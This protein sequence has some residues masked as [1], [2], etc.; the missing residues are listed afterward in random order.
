VTL[1]ENGAME[2]RTLQ[3]KIDEM[4]GS[5]QR[6]TSAAFYTPADIEMSALELFYD[7]P[8]IDVLRPIAKQLTR[9]AV[10][11]HRAAQR[12]WP[13]VTDCDL[14]DRAFGELDRAGI[15]SRQNFTCC[16]T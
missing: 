9:E 5:I 13:S 7:D 4:R 1:F 16:G 2:M 14:L 11:A 8:E 12:R 3:Q 15:V 10:E 6:R